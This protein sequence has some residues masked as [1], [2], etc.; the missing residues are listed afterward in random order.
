MNDGLHV[1]NHKNHGLCATHGSVVISNVSPDIAPARLTDTYANT[2]P[3]AV[4]VDNGGLFGVFEG[5]GVGSTNP[6]YA[7][8]GD[9]II[10]YENVVN[11]QLTGIT[12]NIDDTLSYTYTSGTEIRKYELAGVS[13][14]RINKEHD[15]TQVT[16]SNPLDLD[17][18]NVKLDMSATA[19]L[20]VGTSFP[21]LYLNV[22]KSTGGETV[23]ATQNII[24]DVI[25]PVIQTMTVRGIILILLLEQ[26]LHIQLLVEKHH[27]LIKDLKILV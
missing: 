24:F 20:S 27:M 6:G 3:T 11:N 5:V 7:I 22:T 14:R 17:Y 8:I 26:L 25:K 4:S 10:S 19:L 1:V 15:L 18:Y 13:L 21:K 23:T 16:V 12:R 2:A 9:E